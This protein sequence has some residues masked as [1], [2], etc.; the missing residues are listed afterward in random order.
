MKKLFLLLAFF[1]FFSACSAGIH[2][3]V[4]YQDFREVKKI[5]ENGTDIT[6]TDRNGNT[7]LILAAYYGSYPI[8]K[9]LCEEGADVNIQNNDGWSALLYAVYYGHDINIVKVL[10]DNNASINLTNKFGYDA[11][12]YA[13]KYDR[14]D[15]I[16]LLN[17]AAGKST[18]DVLTARLYSEEGSIYSANF[19]ETAN[20][21][22]VVR[23]ELFGNE[24]FVG[25]YFTVIKRDFNESFLN[26]P[27]G[28]IPLSIS[29][30]ETGPQ[31]THVTAVG[32]KG[33]QIKCVSFPRGLH[34][35]GSC[36]DS[37]GRTYQL[38]Y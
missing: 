18:S 30:T 8:V 29:I 1:F 27:W 7:P 35:I 21:Q 2:K 16:K 26:T 17:I 23:G 28:P 20:G 6:S 13:R 24:K 36:R 9:Y 31:I 32:N 12:W 3:A 15:M 34:G 33:T 22:G 25:E 5:V 14:K 11:L 10:I 4:G 38:H 19:M 37:N